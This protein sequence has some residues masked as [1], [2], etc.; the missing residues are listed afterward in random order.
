MRTSSILIVGGLAAAVVA[1]TLVFAQP[2]SAPQQPA[3]SVQPPTGTSD[4]Q[5]QR[6]KYLVALGDC[7]ACHTQQGGARFAGGRAVQTPF[8]T[9]YS[10]N[11]TPDKDTGIGDWTADQFY[12]ALHEGI[13]DEG[14]HLYPA[15]PY[16]YYTGITREDSDAMLAYMK[17]IPAVRHDFERNQLPFPFNQRWLLTFWNALFLDK[18]PYQ[19]NPSKSPQWNRG[20]YLVQTLGHCEACHTAKNFLGAP[21]HDQAFRG[22]TFGTWYAP[23][24]T[25]NRRSGIGGWTDDALREFLRQGTNVHSAASGEMGE[26][27]AFSTSQMNDDDLQAVITY[28][29]GLPASPEPEVKQPDQAVMKQGEAIFQDTCSACHR[30]DGQGVPRF[31]PPL[32]QDANLQQSDPTSVLHFILAG[33]RK[34]PTD[35]AA[36]PLAMPAYDWKLGDQQIAAVAT[37]VRNSWGN[38]ASPVTAEQVDKLRKQLPRP[39]GTPAQADTSAAGGN[40][41]AH[42]GPE[43]LGRAGTDSRDNGTPNAGRAATNTAL[44]PATHASD[45]ASAA[46][47]GNPATG[48]GTSGAGSTSGGGSTA[49]GGST[50]G[51]GTSG[52]GT[53]GTSGGAGA[54]GGGAKQQQ[55]GHPAGVPSPGPG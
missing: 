11:I 51:G 2:K 43:T 38:R 42:P 30:M 53:S 14:H 36:T 46:G 45:A 27:V 28:L 22:G 31:F 32:Q 48:G 1:T 18:G 39:Q 41:L 50:S 17:S 20:A 21:K 12:R 4:V 35:R 8:G 6:G 3:P 33:T 15:F 19:A 26:V 49:G 52:S 37:F 29:R 23:D 7:V 34:V 47:G 40:P 9:I 10:A 54:G 5:V 24:I 55:G 16:N 13:D 25:G 44:I